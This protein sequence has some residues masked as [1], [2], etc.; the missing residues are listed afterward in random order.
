MV[1]ILP[2]FKVFSKEWFDISS[3]YYILVWKG[4]VPSNRLHFSLP[5]CIFNAPDMQK[6]KV[7]QAI[8]HSRGKLPNKESSQ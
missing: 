4:L 6:C 1:W 2:C 8:S 7:E 5:A 3:R